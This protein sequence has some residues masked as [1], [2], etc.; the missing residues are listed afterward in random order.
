L[1]PVRR[2]ERIGLLANPARQ[3][4][5]IAAFTRDDPEVSCEAEDDLRLADRGMAEQ[6]RPFALRKRQDL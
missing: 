3:P 2:E 5:G 4:A 1:R 6:Q